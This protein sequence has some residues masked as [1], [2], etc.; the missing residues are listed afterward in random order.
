VSG[1]VPVEIAADYTKL[2]G[3]STYTCT[4]QLSFSDGSLQT[5]SLFAIVTP[6]GTTPTDAGRRQARVAGPRAAQNCTPL[7]PVFL[8][9]GTGF[10]A[11]AFQATEVDLQIQ[12]SCG[13]PIDS[14]SI[15]VLGLFSTY[16]GGNNDPAG[17]FQGPY[18]TVPGTYKFEW[19]PTKMPLNVSQSAVTL[20]AAYTSSA[21]NLTPL[22][23]NLSGTVSLTPNPTYVD[24]GGI[25]N[26]ASFTSQVAVGAII[27]IFGG[28]LADGESQ[29]NQVPLPTSLE[30]TKVLV[31]GQAVPL[32]YASS[33]QINAQLPYNLPPNAPQ[34]LIVVRD[35][36]QT[37]PQT[38]TL[39]EAQPA[40]FTTNAG[41]YGQGAIVGPDNITLADA[42]NPVSVGEIVVI[43]CAGLGPV[44][45]TVIAGNPTP[46]NPPLPQVPAGLTV[47]IGNVQATDI[48]YAGLSP[49]FVGLYQVNVQVPDG[50]TAGDAVPVTITVG[51]LQSQPGVTMA[52]AQ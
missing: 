16:S 43:Y 10:I 27:A 4:V 19:T 1:S 42:S 51:N 31:N 40:I 30:G 8:N 32:F 52:V 24:A 18:S 35:N 41:G 9:P 17:D 46:P 7:P 37:N 44:T 29:A 25:A 11:T 5:V 15:G 14:Q 28:N 34:Q 39:V 20:T 50:V 12:D 13:N 36:T 21:A 3:P 45:P 33:T 6:T 38:F 49:D 47:T 2:T 48:L 22:T 26:A 23:G